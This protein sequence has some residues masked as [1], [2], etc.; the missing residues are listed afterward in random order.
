MGRSECSP[1]VWPSPS[2]DSGDVQM[3]LLFLGSVLLVRNVALFI[4]NIPPMFSQCDTDSGGGNV[5]EL[6]GG[7]VGSK[8]DPECFMVHYRLRNHFINPALP[9]PTVSPSWDLAN[10]ISR[11]RHNTETNTHTVQVFALI[12]LSNFYIHE[13][14]KRRS[15]GILS[16]GA[17][18]V[19]YLFICVCACVVCNHIILTQTRVF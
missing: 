7:R 5:K 13:K 14:T 17:R 3:T 4:P 10:Q 15:C 2:P 8:G 1:L 9:L 16:L 11:L 19:I 18:P 6:Y 12:S